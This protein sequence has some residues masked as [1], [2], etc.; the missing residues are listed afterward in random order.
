M[1]QQE[2]LIQDEIA[3]ISFL[4]NKCL[5]HAQQAMEAEALL[6]ARKATEGMLYYVAHQKKYISDTK[7]RTIQKLYRYF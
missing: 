2:V 5:S 7:F 4:A 6:A 1:N 3:R